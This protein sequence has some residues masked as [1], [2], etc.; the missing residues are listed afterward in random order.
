VL[1][2]RDFQLPF[3]TSRIADGHGGCLYCARKH[4]PGAN[5]SAVS[6]PS[7]HW[8]PSTI[9]VPAQVLKNAFDSALIE[10]YRKPIGFVG[11]GSWRGARD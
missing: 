11:Y 7:W 2:L 3:S 5:V 9:T 1:D 4:R 6:T 10:W 8:S